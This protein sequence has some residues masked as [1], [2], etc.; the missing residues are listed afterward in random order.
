MNMRSTN[1]PACQLIQQPLK[2]LL[3]NQ[4][5]LCCNQVLIP[6][7]NQSSR[8]A[9]R[10]TPSP[11]G[12]ERS[13]PGKRCLLTQRDRPCRYQ[14]HWTQGISPD[15]VPASVILRSQA[16]QASH[17]W[18]ASLLEMWQRNWEGNCTTC[19]EQKRKWW[20]GF[21]SL[22]NGQCWKCVWQKKEGHSAS[23]THRKMPKSFFESYRFDIKGPES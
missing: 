4:S 1:N 16:A 19:S 2:A 15:H 9:F 7:H 10:S 17:T 20:G 21:A 22:A 5:C 6:G 14:L 12:R 11:P 3:S 18:L 23:L 13:P 8:A